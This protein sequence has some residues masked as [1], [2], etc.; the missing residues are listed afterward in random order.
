MTNPATLHGTLWWLLR[1]AR[2]VEAVNNVWHDHKEIFAM[3]KADAP[4]LHDD[5]IAYGARRKA[6][7]QRKVA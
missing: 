1:L 2:T 5:L 6:E 7:L 4:E 3:L